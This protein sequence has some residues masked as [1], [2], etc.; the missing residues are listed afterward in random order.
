MFH[1]DASTIANARFHRSL[2]VPRSRTRGAAIRSPKPIATAA[3]P[4]R[5]R[6]S[7]LI[8]APSSGAPSSDAGF[9]PE[10]R[11]QG[12][13]APGEQDEGDDQEAEADGVLERRRDRGPGGERVLEQGEHE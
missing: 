1:A 10:A 8:G 7:A 2:T 6:R 3:R 5:E 13:E 12:R 11:E 9:P 4:S